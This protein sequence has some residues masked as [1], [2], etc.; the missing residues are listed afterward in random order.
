V[1]LCSS[2]VAAGLRRCDGSA[3]NEVVVQGHRF[4][5]VARIFETNCADDATKFRDTASDGMQNT[6]RM[7]RL[8]PSE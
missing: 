1:T 7:Q 5:F 6:L 8:K 4:K 3:W 2:G